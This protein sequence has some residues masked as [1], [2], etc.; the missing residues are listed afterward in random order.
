MVSSALVRF[1]HLEYVVEEIVS[2]EHFMA[3]VFFCIGGSVFG[4][5][6]FGMQFYVHVRCGAL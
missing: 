5:C 2:S 4:D 1:T 3:G 6:F